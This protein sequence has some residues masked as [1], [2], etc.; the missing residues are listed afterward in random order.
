MTAD[1]QPLCRGLDAEGISK[2]PL[3]RLDGIAMHQAYRAASLASRVQLA[4]EN[5]FLQESGNRSMPEAKHLGRRS[6]ADP[7]SLS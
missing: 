3:K 1:T 7:G 2:F 5:P 6:L 4:F